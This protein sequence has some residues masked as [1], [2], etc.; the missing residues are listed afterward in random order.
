MSLLQQ[1]QSWKVLAIEGTKCRGHVAS[2]KGE[3][4]VDR[5][6]G[7]AVCEQQGVGLRVIKDCVGISF[8][9]KTTAELKPQL[10]CSTVHMLQVYIQICLTENLSP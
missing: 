10:G 9:E 7:L 5:Y 4:F 1:T 3:I 6:H 8:K 2:I